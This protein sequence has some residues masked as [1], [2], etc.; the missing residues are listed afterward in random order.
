M[1]DVPRTISYQAAIADDKGN[2]IGDNTYQVTARLYAD[3]DGQQPVW[4]GTYRVQAKHGVIDL[5]LG[6]GNFPLP[7]ADKMS[8]PLWLGIQLSNSGELDYYAPLSAAP[9]ALTVPNGAI[10]ANKLA[11][12][13][14]TT[15]KVNMDYVSSITVNGEKVTGK[16]S[17]LNIATGDG[18][19]AVI[20]PG[21]NTLMLTSGTGSGTRGKGSGAQSSVVWWAL[22]GNSLGT[23]STD[24][25]GTTGNQP[26]WIKVNGT[27][28]TG[29]VMRYYPY[30]GGTP[31]IAG[32]SFKNDVLTN[33]PQGAVIAGGGTT[34]EYNQVYADF[35]T[36][37]GGTGNTS[38]RYGTVA[39]GE[40]NHV[41]TDYGTVGGGLWNTAGDSN[42]DIY[43]TVG[44]GRWNE[45]REEYSTIAGGD[46]NSA[47]SAYTS[48]GGG[49]ANYIEE[50]GVWA[51]HFST[52]AGGR[53]NAIFDQHAFIGGGDS[54]VIYRNSDYG[55]IGGGQRNLISNGVT[56][57]GDS[58]NELAYSAILGGDRNTIAGKSSSILGGRRLTLKDYSV[59][60]NGDTLNKGVDISAFKQT[61]YLGDVDLWIGNIDNKARQLRFYQPNTDTAYPA[62]SYYSSFQAGSQAQ[63]IAYTLPT[64]LPSPGQ[65]LTATAVTS[66]KVTLAWTD[67]GAGGGGGAGWLLHGNSSVPPPSF[68][69]GTNDSEAFEIHIHNNTTDTS[70][71]NQRVMRYEEGATSPNI[72][73]GSSANTLGNGLSGAAILSG[74]SIY[75]PNINQGPYSVIVGGDSNAIYN[76]GADHNTIGGGF[77]NTEQNPSFGVIAGGWRNTLDTVA[78]GSTISGGWLNIVQPPLSFIGGG[79]GNEIHDIGWAYGGVI[80]G[81][82]RNKMVHGITSFM[83]GGENNFLQDEHS[84]FVGGYADTMY[85]YGEFLGGGINNTIYWGSDT[86][87]L[88]GGAHNYIGGGKYSFLGGGLLNSISGTRAVI[89]GGDS[90]LIRERDTS[91]VIAG[92]S[93]NSIDSASSFSAVLG[94][95]N[96]S[97]GKTSLHS[98]VVGGE[99]NTILSNVDHS[100]I[101]GGWQN[102]IDHVSSY[103]VLAGGIDN[104]I[105]PITQG[106]QYPFPFRFGSLEL[107]WDGLAVISGGQSNTVRSSLAVVAGGRGNWI[108][109]AADASVIGGGEVNFLGAP[110][111][112]IAGGGFNRVDSTAAFAAI[113]GGIGLIARDIAQVVVGSYNIPEY[114]RSSSDNGIFIVGSGTDTVHRANAFE[115]SYNGHATVFQTLGTG[116]VPSGAAVYGATYVDNEIRAW[117][118][119]NVAPGTWFTTVTADFG[120]LWVTRVGAGQYRVKLNIKDPMTGVKDTL[121]GG[122]SVVVT[123]VVGVGAPICRIPVVTPLGVGT[124]PDAEAFDIYILDP[125][126]PDC[127]QADCSFSFH[128]CGRK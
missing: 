48:I 69:L 46:T 5:Q 72:L 125:H 9:Y 21:T 80:V 118:T 103:S 74:G 75:G 12:G 42:D 86:S 119:V 94:G 115:V 14:V 31:N 38:A 65:V 70:G 71:G 27:S 20:D 26:V 17:A 1:P 23:P 32:G 108:D 43:A 36:I 123:P 22:G 92:G 54:N 76:L 126:S 84:A 122:L 44:G 73:G 64:T 61:A 40:H 67:S 58:L 33:S 8:T 47:L 66:P 114:S 128:V 93:H 101:G 112:T 96:N 109:T 117:A 79:R 51:S 60:F 25:L 2:P 99:E 91:S 29:T 98:V 53:R 13:A 11:P 34:T 104:H 24:Y 18:L 87:T 121:L 59:G 55:V 6:S 83:G 110:L 68:Y 106:I 57:A 81:G 28:D 30:S 56:A 35:G 95:R 10:T 120:V 41:K 39:G 97:I 102:T 78:W 113:P 82:V 89:G 19:G 7:K 4:W 124:P 45:A 49:Q 52:I 111:A 116:A 105:T 37:G 3:A 90:N 62:T 63:N 100:I 50:E 77:G 127:G 85:G 107:G 16:G 88:V 15:D